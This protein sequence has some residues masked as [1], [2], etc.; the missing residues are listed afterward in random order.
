MSIFGSLFGKVYNRNG[1]G[2]DKD[3]P[4]QPDF[5][6]FFQVFARKFGSLIKL[7]SA[8][9]IPALPAA[10]LIYFLSYM[11]MPL[12]LNIGGNIIAIDIFKRFVLPLILVLVYPFIAGLSFVSRNFVRE[13][14]TFIY[15]DF[16]EHTKKNFKFF[17]L[18]GILLYIIYVVLSLSFEF[19]FY[20][21]FS[22]LLFIVPFLFT[23]FASY[24][25]IAAQFFIPVMAVTFDLKFS[26]I[27][28]NAFIFA[29]IALPRCLIIVFLGVLLFAYAIIFTP[30]MILLLFALIAYF[31]LFGFSFSMYTVNFIVY[32]VIDKFMIRGETEIKTKK[33]EDA[34]TLQKLTEEEFKA[35]SEIQS[36]YVFVNGKLVKREDFNEE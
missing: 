8:F 1:A 12:H 7:N 22:N 11:N 27:Y 10:A 4:K 19:Y 31:L 5:I 16:F 33:E 35:I 25:I 18:N 28:K 29:M 3:E 14:H 34:P 32:P 30:L 36:E 24:M 20:M 9:L 2:V 26:A 6:R 13:E 15:S 23:I 21:M 17:F